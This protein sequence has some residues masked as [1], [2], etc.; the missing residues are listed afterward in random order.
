M[1]Y[2][3]WAVVAIR[4]YNSLS[5]EVARFYVVDLSNDF[6]VKCSDFTAYI[7]VL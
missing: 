1:A 6:D 3:W 5:K 7:D 4:F 2:S